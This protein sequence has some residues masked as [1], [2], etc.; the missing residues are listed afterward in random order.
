M[1]MPI[2]T[3][4]LFLVLLAPGTFLQIEAKTVIS[5]ES[6]LSDDPTT[7]YSRLVNFFPGDPAAA[8]PERSRRAKA[9]GEVVD[10]NPPRFRWFYNPDPSEETTSL[11]FSFR[12]QISR[13]PEFA[14]L[15]V[16]VETPYNFYNTIAPLTGSDTYYWRVEYRPEDSSNPKTWSE[17]RSFSVADDAQVWDRTSMARPDFSG[18]GHPRLLFTEESLPRLRELVETHEESRAIF[19]RMKRHVEEDVFT[20][21]WWNKLPASD[22][23]WAFDQRY[24]E[25]GHDLA[26]VA[27]VYVI[28]DDPKYADVIPQAVTI[29]RHPIGGPASPEGA[30]GEY[31]YYANED[32]TQLTEFLAL[33]YDWLYPKL[34]EEERASFV[35]SLDWRIEHFVY[36][37]SWMRTRD[38]GTRRM[39]GSSLA[40]VGASHA[41]EGF[42]DTFPACLAI[43][44]ESESAR[45]GFHL[46]STTWRVSDRRTDSAKA[47]TRVLDTG[48]PSGRGRSTRCHI[49]TASSR[50]T[51]SHPTRGFGGPVSSS[52]CRRRS[53][54]STRPGVTDRTVRVTIEA[55]TFGDTGSS[56]T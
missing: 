34:S 15:I 13:D 47:G 10:L 3:T 31:S 43:Y 51:T 32:A 56:P 40:I 41:F 16:D 22:R 54:S 50:N 46:A 4:I 19:E 53:G 36:D 2:R 42:F 21:A 11:V 29:A 45:F 38:D 8:S 52:D 12:F 18:V 48:I 39:T 6:V 37:F 55:V 9:G 35:T 49:W 28:T 33:L 44:E 26:V 14:D 5:S 25:V 20:A 24:Y 7:H 30:Q 23:D 17:V 27:F 1:P